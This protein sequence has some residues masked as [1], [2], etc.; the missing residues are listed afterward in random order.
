LQAKGSKE[1]EVYSSF[2]GK[3]S[4]EHGKVYLEIGPKK[5]FLRVAKNSED[6]SFIR[7]LKYYRWNQVY[8]LWEISHTPANLT[9]VRNYFSGRLVEVTV[10]QPS[11]ETKS[12]SLPLPTAKGEKAG[13][14]EAKLLRVIMRREGRLRL[15]FAYAPALVELIKKLPYYKWDKDN[16]WW[17]V[18]DSE[19]IRQSLQE[20]V[21][22]QGWQ[23]VYEQMEERHSEKRSQREDPRFRSCPVEFVEKLALQRYSPHTIKSYSHLF[24]EFINFYPGHDPKELTE[25]EVLA[26]LRHLVEVRKVSHSYQNQAI[27]AIKFYYER[28]LGGARRFYFV[29]RPIRE[30]TLPVVLSGEEVKRLLEVTGNLKHKCMLMVCYSAGLRMSELLNLQI[31]DIDSKRMQ[32]F[33]RAGKGK[34]DRITLLSEKT[35]AILR[36]YYIMYTPKT[37]LFEGSDGGRYGERSVQQVLKGAVECAGIRKKVTLHTLRHSF[38][39]HLLEKGTDLRYIQV[40][41]GHDSS[42]TTEIYTHVST[43]MIEAIKSPMDSL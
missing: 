10:E 15:V 28:V 33:V 32:I 34:K 20:W 37:Y 13:R 41:L 17:S 26:Y 12:Q 21:Q 42:K 27:N 5:L 23:V 30:K 43:K 1:K 11:Q 7:S 40:L 22:A 39:T 6:I 35:L 16:K 31:K 2:T 29:D 9:L 25:K 19:K 4:L 24:E 8:F 36:E 14:R 18:P 38:A 3:E